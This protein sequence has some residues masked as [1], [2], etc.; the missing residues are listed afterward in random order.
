MTKQNRFL[1]ASAVL[2]GCSVYSLSGVS[3]PQ[4]EKNQPNIIFI[5]A[6]DLGYGDLACYGQEKIKTP[7]IDRM[8]S[9]GMRFTNF[10]AGNAVCSPS[11]Y[12]LLTGK[13][14][15][16]SAVR[17][18]F[19]IGDW[20]SFLGQLPIPEGE[21]TIFEVV[22][23]AGYRTA[24]Y[25]KWGVGRAESSGAP[26]QKGVDDFYGFNCQRHAHTYYPRYVEGN[27]GEKIWLEGNDRKDGGKQYV[28]DLFTNKAFEFL[29]QN[30]D[31]SF[32]LYLPYTLPHIPF[33]IPDLGIYKDKN[34]DENFKRQAAMISKLDTDVGRIIDLLKELGIDDN[35]II[36]L[37]S[38][39]GAHGDGGTLEFFKAAGPLRGKKG[40]LYEGGIRTPLIVRWPGKIE[41]GVVSD[42]IGAF[43]DIMPTFA[44][45]T[46]TDYPEETTDGISFLPELLNKPQPEHEFLYWEYFKTDYSW[47]PSKK[48]NRTDLKS[49]AVRVGKWKAIR[50]NLH[51]DF[52]G[53]PVDFSPIELYNLDEDVAESNN[54]ANNHPDVVKYLKGLLKANH[55]T[56]ENFKFETK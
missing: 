49:Q 45:L 15:G 28:H 6:D 35:T 21:T 13:H 54:V 32:F 31:S 20:D 12:S 55:S 37:T 4:V 14:P 26:D 7:N 44:E 30:K 5:L 34:W 22:K 16:H 43:W 51:S 1:V 2:W 25:G 53:A 40:D 46:N 27:R 29:K 23:Q 18:N 8:A 36:F 42:Y 38:D 39:N 33:M 17:G 50:H 11:R 56:S 48:T 10:Y 24:A 41:A 47:K 19:E 52:T 9:E 3:K